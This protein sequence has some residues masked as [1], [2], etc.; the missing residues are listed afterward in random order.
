MRPA[1]CAECLERDIQQGMPAGSGGAHAR[2]QL[3]MRG[4]A[5]ERH[6]RQAAV[7]HMKPLPE[8]PL[9]PSDPMTS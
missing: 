2:S 6:R 3:D 5:A 8:H 4:G 7:G 1:A 9:I